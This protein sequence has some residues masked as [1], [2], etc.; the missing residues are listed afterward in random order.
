MARSATR[1]TSMTLV[2]V[3]LPVAGIAIAGMWWWGEPS[4][5]HSG[6]EPL[7]AP[8]A[9]ALERTHLAA[10]DASRARGSSTIETARQELAP[11]P[12]RSADALVEAPAPPRP[13]PSGTQ[14]LEHLYVE[15]I[16]G[17]ERTDRSKPR[18]EPSRRLKLVQRLEKDG[19]SVFTIE[20]TDRELP[21]EGPVTL[22]HENGSQAS[23]GTMRNGKRVGF[24]VEWYADGHKSSEG[25]YFHGTR[26]GFW[27]YW[28]ENGELREAGEYLYGRKEGLW[29]SWHENGEKERVAHYRNDRAED[30]TT[31]WHA[32][33]TKAAEGQLEDDLREGLWLEWHA[34]GSLESRGSYRHGRAEGRWEFWDEAGE[35]DPGSS[36]L[37]DDGRRIAE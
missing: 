18:T 34:S 32:D 17:P 3:L 35:L 37:Y 9:G 24:W 14:Q 26:H 2:P 23:S 16:A 7:R 19:A 33:G 22:R 15:R 29:T 21:E 4:I 30:R 36:G 8:L 28:Y 10:A 13:A 11:E 20:E 1:S 6:P 25:N 31:I 5:T 27:S 12:A